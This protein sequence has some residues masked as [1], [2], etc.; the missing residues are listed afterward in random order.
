MKTCRKKRHVLALIFAL[1]IVFSIFPLTG[2]GQAPVTEPDQPHVLTA[3]P[4]VDNTA[5]ATVE[6]VEESA[7]TVET[8][9][10]PESTAIPVTIEEQM[11]LLPSSFGYTD[12]KEHQYVAD[13]VFYMRYM[14]NGV[15]KYI[16]F[17]LGAFGDSPADMFAIDVFSEYSVC[18]AAIETMLSVAVNGVSPNT[19][20]FTFYPVAYQEQDIVLLEC[21]NLSGFLDSLSSKDARDLE[22]AISNSGY[23]SGVSSVTLEQLARLYLY[24]LKDSEKVFSENLIP[25]A[26]ATAEPT[27]VA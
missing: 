5:T 19:S 16:F 17:C 9:Q 23:R 11:K 22:S 27:P 6:Q 10:V 15:E 7:D 1:V 26:Q 12:L 25:S 2:C 8:A 18:S 24:A 3:A 4:T 21:G 14:V 20:D 13:D